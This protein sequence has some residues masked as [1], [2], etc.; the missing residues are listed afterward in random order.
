ML[1]SLS[2]PI[3]TNRSR[4][5]ES[6]CPSLLIRRS[7]GAYFSIKS[8]SSSIYGVRSN[9][10]NQAF[11]TGMSNRR[12][13]FGSGRQLCML[14]TL[15]NRNCRWLLFRFGF[16]GLPSHHSYT[17][18]GYGT[19]SPLRSIPTG[20]GAMSH[21]P[22]LQQLQR[23]IL[24]FCPFALVRDTQLAGIDFAV[25]FHPVKRVVHPALAALHPP[26]AFPVFREVL[27]VGD[28]DYTQYI[29][30]HLEH[31]ARFFALQPAGQCIGKSLRW[32]SGAPPTVFAFLVVELGDRVR[33]IWHMIIVSYIQGV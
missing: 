6:A 15:F 17:T 25:Q 22:L 27:P 1:D 31:P 23:S 9:Q 5:L 19:L 33:Y 28:I 14:C 4:R 2:S 20:L 32:L 10:W 11:C 7:Q 16:I 8:F 26:A 29:G 3:R 12:A 30:Q 13:S 21:A 24:S 18:T